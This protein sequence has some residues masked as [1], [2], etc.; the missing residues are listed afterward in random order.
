MSEM[1][2]DEKLRQA[3]DLIESAQHAIAFTGA[4]ISLESGV[5]TFRGSGSSIW[6]KYDPDDIE[7]GHFEADPKKSWATIKAC[8]YEFMKDQDIRPNKAHYVLA[9]L[10]K[11]G[12]LK[13]I[14]TQNIDA[15]H[16]K[17]GAEDVVEF[18]GTT[19]TISCTKCGERYAS[20]GVDLSAD[21]PRCPK[22]G[23]VLKPDFVF[24]GE[25]IPEKAMLRS[26]DEVDKADLCIMVGTS[27]V[28]MPAGLIPVMVS[29]HGGKV[30]E[31]NPE[32]TQLTERCTDVF[33]GMGA[34]DAF[35]EIEKMLKGDGVL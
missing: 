26:A 11:A 3:V 22:C 1:S 27:A 8:F 24:F 34:V 30:I 33:V 2:C 32:K 4:G 16:Q 9:E 14:I 35:T 5:P 19:A 7:V 21:V 18:H 6:S 23:G 12:R 25:G 17:A 31:V 15:L 13:T 28:V 10:Q 29:R 20:D